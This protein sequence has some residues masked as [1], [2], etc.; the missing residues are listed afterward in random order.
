MTVK[1]KD[2]DSRNGHTEQEKPYGMNGT[3][4]VTVLEP[5]SEA[6]KAVTEEEYWRA[7]NCC[8]QSRLSEALSADSVPS[9][10][11]KSSATAADRS[12]SAAR[13]SSEAKA[14]SATVPVSSS[15]RAGDQPLSAVFTMVSLR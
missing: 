2:K 11:S 13:N 8:K 4:A 6:G 12:S 5:V 7:M 3:A 1:F 10:A 9:C 14:S 15:A